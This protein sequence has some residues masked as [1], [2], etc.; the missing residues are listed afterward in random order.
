MFS[1]TVYINFYF[2]FINLLET[3]DLIYIYS[4]PIESSTMNSL[5]LQARYKN[6]AMTQDELRRRREEGSIQL[7]KQKREQNFQKRRN[8]DG[9]PFSTATDLE[10]GAEVEH[11][12]VRRNLTRCFL[13]MCI[14]V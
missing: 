3:V 14:F 7:R 9:A 5:G 8:V 6:R 10:I 13:L 4:M 1:F 2:Y 11:P 12:L